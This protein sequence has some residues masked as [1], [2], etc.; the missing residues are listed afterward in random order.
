MYLKSQLLEVHQNNI[1][2]KSGLKQT[3]W[4]VISKKTFVLIRAIRVQTKSLRLRSR[5]RYLIQCFSKIN[6]I[7]F[8]IVLAKP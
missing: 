2:L 4:S 3:Y 1:N 5:S 7:L 8:C 6:P